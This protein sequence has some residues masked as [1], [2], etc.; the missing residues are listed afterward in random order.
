[1]I[2]ASGRNTQ[3]YFARGSGDDRYQGKELPD[4]I[5]RVA[6]LAVTAMLEDIVV[7]NI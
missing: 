2:H 4:A 3:S 1:M 5:I 6:L 7:R